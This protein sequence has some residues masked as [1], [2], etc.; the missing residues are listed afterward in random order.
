VLAP[1]SAILTLLFFSSTLPNGIR[2]VE[3]PAAGDSLEIVAGYTT[4]GLKGFA[5]TDAARNLTFT[6]YA[7]GGTIEFFDELDRTGVRIAAPR[8]S[9]PMFIDG[10][11][12]ALFT[13]VPKG[14]VRRAAWDFRLKVE[15]EIRNAL[16]G[17]VGEEAPYATDD[18]FVL[19]SASSSALRSQLEAIPK[20]P[21]RNKPE[22]PFSRLPAER[23]LRFKSDLPTGAVIFASPLPGVYYRQWYLVLLLDRLIRRVVP[24]QLNTSLSLTVQPH[25]Y[26]MELTVPAG[27]FPEPAEENFLQEIQR[28]QFT[29]ATPQQLAT[30]RQEALAYLDSKTVREWFASH[31]IAERRDEG[32]Q[33]IQSMTPD[34]MRIAARDL[35]IMNR[36]IATWPPLPKQTAVVVES[37]TA[38]SDAAGSADSADVKPFNPLNPRLVFPAHTHS[39]LSTLPPERLPSG[40]SLVPSNIYGVFISGSALTT[41]DR[42]PDVQPFQAYRGDRIL[43]LVPP[44]SIEPA[45]RLWSNFKGS[46]NRD[47]GVPR[48]KVST[49]DLPALFVLKTMLDLKLIEAGW[50]NNV[51]L[52]IDANEGSALQ[53][54]TDA[55][56]QTQILTWIKQIASEKPADGYFAWAREVAMHRFDTARGHLQA[57][58]WERDP[59]GVIQ[60]L[61][62][63]SATHVQDVARIYF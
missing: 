62:I 1:I 13:E 46:D 42:E 38:G 41:Y 59:L 9:L 14:D 63:I 53:I 21:G 44:D 49:G 35:L 20:R 2:L 26:R 57:L 29:P 28:L 47:I 54:R 23:T 22:E 33:W 10:V 55:G 30:A 3:L 27:Q 37:L 4:G 25:Y 12:P 58:I 34:D 40:V 24:L 50:W 60:D 16:L 7:A 19:I 36:V 6:A 5:S 45:R 61:E 39:S 51:E 43:V 32:A 8:W 52:R 31:D 15:D 56:R 17:P 11:L 18:A 48:G